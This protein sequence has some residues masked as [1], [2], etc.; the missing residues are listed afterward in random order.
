MTVSGLLSSD[1]ANRTYLSLMEASKMSDTLNETVECRK[2]CP[3]LRQHFSRLP[4]ATLP[5]HSDLL[6]VLVGP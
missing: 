2:G 6:S 5:Q 3:S 4:V 1:L